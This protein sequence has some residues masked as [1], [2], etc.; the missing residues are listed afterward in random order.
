MVKK[1]RKLH[2][3]RRG[4]VGLKMGWR[5]TRLVHFWLKKK[6]SGGAAKRIRGGTQQ[7]GKL[8][9]IPMH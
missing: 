7:S 9:C 8:A 1:M 4:L 6:V 2:K 5:G 3:R